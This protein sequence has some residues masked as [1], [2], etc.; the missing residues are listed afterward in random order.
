MQNLA[1]A[2]TVEFGKFIRSISNLI[3]DIINTKG[4]KLFTRLR[5]RITN[6]Y[7]NIDIV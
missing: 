3:Y 2:C 4:L 6:L 1:C 5:L 7:K